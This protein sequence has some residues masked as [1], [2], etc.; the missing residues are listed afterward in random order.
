MSKI[1][2]LH[3]AIALALQLVTSSFL[4]RMA[5]LVCDASSATFALS[6]LAQSQS[7]QSQK[8][9][10]LSGQPKPRMFSGPSQAALKL[11]KLQP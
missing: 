6:Q 1:L 9:Q 7:A 4:P 10:A 5:L 8:Q 3:T 2:F 11:P